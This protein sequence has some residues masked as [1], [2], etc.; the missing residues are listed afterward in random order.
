MGVLSGIALLG[1]TTSCSAVA[2]DG[3]QAVTASQTIRREARSDEGAS[4]DVAGNGGSSSIP[5]GHRARDHHDK[6][7]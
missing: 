4:R 7:R 6:R 1:P 5:S 3:P 2:T